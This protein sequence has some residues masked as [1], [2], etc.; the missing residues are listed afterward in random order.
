MD[1]IFNPFKRTEKRAEDSSG[2]YVQFEEALMSAILSNQSIDRKKALQIP[3]VSGCLE[4]L[5]GT[6]TRLPIKLYKKVDGNVTEITDDKRLKLLNDDTGDTLNA[7]EFWKALI[8]DYFFGTNGGIAYINKKAGEYWSLNYVESDSVSVNIN[9]QKIF[10][11]YQYLVDGQSYYPFDFLKI[12]RRTKDG[13]TN[14]PLHKENSEV[15]NV[16]YARLIFEKVLLTKGGNKKGFFEC[17][18]KLGPDAVEALKTALRDLYSRTEAAENF[19]V[20]N[21]GIKFHESSSSPVEMQLNENK[22]T[23]TKEIC[24]LFGFSSKIVEGGAT[25]EDI[26]QYNSAVI[27]ILTVIETALDRDLLKENEKADMYWAFDTRELTRGNIKE[28]YEAYQIALKEHFLQVDEV[29]KE[30]DYEPLGFN[31]ITLGLG[32][33][34]INPETK[35]VYTPNTNQTTNLE[36]PQLN[37]TK[38]ERANPNHDKSGKFAAGGKFIS[39]SIDNSNSGGIMKSSPK[40]SALGENKFKRGFSEHNLEK[41]WSGESSHKE[42]YPEF[43]KQQYAKRALELIQSKADGKNI[44]GYKN[45]KDQVIRYDTKTN[46]FVKGKPDKGIATMFKPSGGISYYKKQSENDK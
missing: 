5:S 13:A 42:Q 3:T 28:R 1:F 36:K 27:D 8:E 24:K 19:A 39:K 43:T 14:I 9:Q 37:I 6:I 35:E 31:F 32:D 16:A 29:R 21:D 25:E 34:L 23:D 46:D 44:L 41:H 40:I 11:D 10:K 33:V 30:E 26:K 18:K 17:E 38:E 4:K 45:S 2:G 12:R 22:Q 20:L 7:N 15:F